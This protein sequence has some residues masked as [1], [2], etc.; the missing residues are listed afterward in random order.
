M[1]EW[2]M[3]RDNRGVTLLEMVAAIALT[4]VM[5]AVAVMVYQSIFHLSK[6]GMQ[7]YADRASVVRTMSELE[8]ELVDII[9]ANTDVA[10]ELRYTNGARARALVFDPES[11][12]LKLHDLNDGSDLKTASYDQAIFWS[13]A[14]NVTDFSAE[15]EGTEPASD[16]KIL[17]LQIT[18]EVSKVN[19][20]GFRKP[21][22]EQRE[23]RVKLMSLPD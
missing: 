19:V 17:T 6:S 23:L 16:P 22:A 5:L 12:T 20:N 21:A 1:G 13:I 10:N 4:G 9:D 8:Q 2:L 14:D 18:F 15:I 11:K 3:L 7:R